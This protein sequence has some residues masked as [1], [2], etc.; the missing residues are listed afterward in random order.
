MAEAAAA[1]A[2]AAEREK[3][4]AASGT[5]WKG[6]K[7]L[8]ALEAKPS[9]ASAGGGKVAA[10]SVREK[11]LPN[12]QARLCYL[13]LVSQSIK[14]V[15]HQW[16]HAANIASSARGENGVFPTASNG[17]I[18]QGGVELISCIGDSQHAARVVRD[19][20]G[21]VM[22][23]SADVILTGVEVNAVSHNNMLYT[24]KHFPALVK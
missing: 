22:G 8:S 11:E 14:D 24:A 13:T 6:L 23:P 4:Q 10:A 5:P 21:A 1:A 15:I 18:V 12:G 19:P 9:G 17:L 3:E 16:G 2:A 7:F 20:V